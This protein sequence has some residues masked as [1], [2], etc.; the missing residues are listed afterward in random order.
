MTMRVIN[1][2]FLLSLSFVLVTGCG[3]KSDAPVLITYTASTTFS[4]FSQITYIGDNGEEI[5]AEITPGKNVW[6]KTVSI[7]D[8]EYVYFSAT[9]AFSCTMN[10]SCSAVKIKATIKSNG[11]I[12]GEGDAVGED[13]DTPADAKVPILTLD[14]FAKAEPWNTGT[15]DEAPPAE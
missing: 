2:I 13:G 5:I 3:N 6:T 7:N 15:T 14:G 9:A 8:G 1:F 10:N 12:I 4:G 11:Q